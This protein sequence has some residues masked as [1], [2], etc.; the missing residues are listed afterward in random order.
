MGATTKEVKPLFNYFLHLRCFCKIDILSHINYRKNIMAN[1][2]MN[3]KG[4]NGSATAKGYEGW[5][6]LL[7]LSTGVKRNILSDNV[8]NMAD[9]TCGISQFN[10]LRIRKVLDA[11]SN[12]LFTKS[13]A[14]KAVPEV[15]IHICG[16]SSSAGAY[17]QLMLN[18][19]IFT[20]CH[21]HIY[22]DM[23][24]FE[25]LKLNF[26]KIQQTYIQRN[27]LGKT[28]STNRVGYDLATAQSL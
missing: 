13:V 23:A 22:E 9:R 28:V 12:D 20:Q 21:T 1:I 17:Y 5:I 26:A 16:S 18:D 7:G 2:F 10:E 27:N 4:I 15:E 25:S 3:I 24:P 8:G 19:V 14:D 6:S 11:G